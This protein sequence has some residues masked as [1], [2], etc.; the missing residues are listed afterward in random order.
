LDE[1]YLTLEFLVKEMLDMKEK[2]SV[3]EYIRQER[4]KARALRQPAERYAA[5]DHRRQA[6]YA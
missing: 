3:E 4:A 2:M 6:S 1:K 5:P